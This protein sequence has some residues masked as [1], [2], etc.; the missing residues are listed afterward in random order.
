M[1]TLNAL[2]FSTKNKELLQIKSILEILSIINICTTHVL[3]DV[4]QALR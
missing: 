1:R 4:I 2:H 3:N